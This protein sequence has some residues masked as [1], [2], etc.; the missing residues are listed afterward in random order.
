VSGSVWCWGADTWGQL[1]ADGVGDVTCL[2]GGEEKPCSPTAVRVKNLSSAIQLATGRDSACAVTKEQNVWCW[3]RSEIGA[4]GHDDST[5]PLCAENKPCVTAPV[6]IPMLSGVTRITLGHFSGCA[7]K[8]DGTLSCWGQ[9]LFGNLGNGALEAALEA[10]PPTQLALRGVEF[11]QETSLY[12]AHVCA[13]AEN[14]T[15]WCWGINNWSDLGHPTGTAGDEPCDSTSMCNPS[16]QLVTMDG[17]VGGVPL[18]DVG[19]VAAVGTGTCVLRSGGSLWCWGTEQDGVTTFATTQ[20]TPTATNAAPANFG[21]LEIYGRHA[22]LCG[23]QGGEVDT[24]WC[25]GRN[26][27]GELGNGTIAGEACAFGSCVRT[28][29]ATGLKGTPAPG[30]VEFTVAI[31]MEGQVWG[32][33]KN[34]Y[35]QT[36]HAPSTAGDQVCGGGAPC[37]PTPVLATALP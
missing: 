27:F 19:S 2:A 18:S 5:D 36:G 34:D 22:H 4:L 37:N 12:S 11:A 14:G 16:P 33:G 15:M 8:A 24:I 23:R 29:Q 17:T 7:R 30:H 35:G 32:W 25:W 21:F 26:D 9:N 1:G 6:Q 3:G 10:T 31:D 28:P 20:S 13:V